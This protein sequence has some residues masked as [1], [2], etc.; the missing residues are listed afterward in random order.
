MEVHSY[1]IFSS[2]RADHT[3]DITEFNNIETAL[4]RLETHAANMAQALDDLKN[5][6]RSFFFYSYR[7]SFT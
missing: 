6:C 4:V 2:S 1:T 7:N 3:R 5:V